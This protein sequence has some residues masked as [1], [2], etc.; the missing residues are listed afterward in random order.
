MR[1]VQW[2]ACITLTSELVPDADC[3][4]HQAP[5]FLKAPVFWCA[6][7]V[8]VRPSL[9]GSPEV[10]VVV[11]QCVR[12]WQRL[13]GVSTESDCHDYSRDYLDAD[14][15]SGEHS[16]SVDYRSCSPSDRLGLVCARRN[17]TGSWRPET[18]LL[19]SWRSSVE[20]GRIS[21]QA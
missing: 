14:R 12:L 8:R 17:G 19:R 18:L 7:R 9:H 20:I 15:I 5:I 11:Y 13:S 6:P 2:E 1:V 4:Q 21:H 3:L 16:D 10:R